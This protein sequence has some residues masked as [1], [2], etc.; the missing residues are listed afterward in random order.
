MNITY[1]NIKFFVC[2]IKLLPTEL[3][4]NGLVE[5]EDTTCS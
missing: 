3:F 2:M 5:I 4:E 1:I